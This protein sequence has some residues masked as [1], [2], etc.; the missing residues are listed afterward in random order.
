MWQWF[1][2]FLEKPSA[3]PS[4]PPHEGPHGQIEAL[5]IAGADMIGIGVPLNRRP[6]E[7]QNPNQFKID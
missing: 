1:S 2:Y 3:S 5:G 4:K 6:R 7:S